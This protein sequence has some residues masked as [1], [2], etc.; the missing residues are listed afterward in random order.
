MSAARN[1]HPIF[2]EILRDIE[3]QPALLARAQ[4][5][6]SERRFSAEP[7]TGFDEPDLRSEEERA[8][9]HAYDL[10]EQRDA[11]RWMDEEKS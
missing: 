8:A 11:D 5:K 2:A 10:Q 1:L 7:M 9:D 4:R 6:A 3:L